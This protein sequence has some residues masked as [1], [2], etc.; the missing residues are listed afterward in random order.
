MNN[1]SQNK[2]MH[3]KDGVLIS[4]IT[5]IKANQTRSKDLR[6]SPKEIIETANLSQE[7]HTSNYED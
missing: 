5:K 1:Q 4:N 6:P 7:E 3:Y 2:N